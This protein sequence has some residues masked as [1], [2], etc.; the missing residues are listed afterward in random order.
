M[1]DFQSNINVNIDTANALASIKALQRQISVFHQEMAQGGAAAQASSAKMQQTLINGINASKGFSAE[2]TTISSSTQSFTNAL[3]KNKLSMGQY[4]RYSMGATKTFGS[5]FKTEFNTISKVARER[6]KDL[7]TQYVK[8]G[9]DGNGALQAIK[10]RPLTLDMKSL[11]TQTAMAAQKQQIFNQLIKQGSTNLLNFGKNTQWAGRQLMVGFTIPL[12]MMG[13]IAI[14]E[15]KKI[16]AQVIKFKRVYGDMFSTDADS[17]EAL[18]NVRRLADEFTKYGIA[19]EKTIGLAAKVAQMGNVGT[20]LEQ[21]VI[22]ATRLSV[23]GGLDQEEALDTTISLTNAFKVEVEDLTNKINFLNAAE[24]QTVL[25]IEDFNTAIPLAGSVVKSLGGEVEDLA[26]FLTAMREG[27]ISASQ[28]ANAL[29][30]SLARLIA[31]SEAAKQRLSEMGINVLGIVEANAGN[32]RGTVTSLAYALENL[33]PLSKARAIEQLFGKFQF[34]RMSTLFANIVDEGSQAN[35]VLGLTVNSAEELAILAE[36]ELGKVEDSSA[37]K[38]SKSLE[39]LKTSLAPIGETF[40]KAITPIV[41]WVANFIKKFDEMGEGTKNF[42][43]GLAAI[44]GA[45]APVLLMAIGLVANG[46]ANLI[47]FFQL[48]SNYFS[49]ASASSKT[50]GEGVS[51]LTQQQVEQLTVAASLDQVHN[52]LTQRFTAETLAVDGLSQAYGRAITTQNAYLASAAASASAPI[53]GSSR[54]AAPTTNTSRYN[55]FLPP[56]GYADGILSVPGPA[57]AGDVV[58]SMLSPGEAVIPA[59]R[60]KQYAPFI[61]GIIAGKIPGF[62]EGTPGAAAAVQT[63]IGGENFSFS[64][65]AQADR[66]AGLYRDMGEYGKILLETLKKS[67]DQSGVIADDFSKIK[68]DVAETAVS[69]GD[70]DVP[71]L[72]ATNTQKSHLTMPFEGDKRTAALGSVGFDK[73]PADLQRNTSAVSNLVA[74]L[75][76]IINQG[77]IEKVGPDGKVTGGVNSSLFEKTWESRPDKLD[78]T[79]KQG[80]LN[81]AD[82]KNVQATRAMDADI[83]KETSR[84]AKER[85]AAGEEVLITDRILAEATENIIAKNEELE[86]ATGDLARVMRERANSLGEARSNPGKGLVQKYMAEAEAGRPGLVRTG[87]GAELGFRTGEVD[88]QGS[89]KVVSR[90]GRTGEVSRAYGS[91][92]SMPGG[93]TRQKNVSQKVVADALDDSELRNETMAAALDDPHISSTKNSRKSPHPNAAIDGADDARAYS[94]ARDKVLRDPYTSG[95]APKLP[96]PPGSP[97]A[98]PTAPQVSTPAQSSRKQRILD[99]I[100]DSSPG[101]AVGKFLA[102]QSGVAVTD[103]KGQVFYDPNEDKSTWAGQMEAQRKQEELLF[104]QKRQQMVEESATNQELKAAGQ[105]VEQGGQKLEVAGDSLQNAQQAKGG[106]N[107]N[108]A[109]GGKRRGGNLAGGV[110]AMGSAAMMTQM[111]GGPVGEAAGAVAAPLMA[112]GGIMPMLS[113]LPPQ[114]QAAALALAAV[115]YATYKLITHFGNV[116]KK[117]AELETALGTGTKAVQKFAEFSGKVTSKEVMDR[118]IEGGIDPF[119][120]QPGKKT[121]GQGFF[122][123]DEGTAFAESVKQ[124]ISTLGTDQ[125]MSKVALQLGQAVAQ[126]ALDTSSAMSIAS[127]IGTQLGD[128]SFAIGVNSQLLSLIDPSGKDLLVDPIILQAKILVEGQENID[129]LLGEGPMNYIEGL[130]YYDARLTDVIEAHGFL[131][132]V[133]TQGD[134]WSAW[135]LGITGIGVAEQ[136]IERMTQIVTQSRDQLQSYGAALDTVSIEYEKRIADATERG[137]SQ[138]EISALAEEAIAKKEE[139]LAQRSATMDKLFA[140]RNV[141]AGQF[142]MGMKKG[143]STTFEGD[144]LKTATTL[145]NQIGDEIGKD[146]VGLELRY[147]LTTGDVPLSTISDIVSE[148]KEFPEISEKRIGIITDFGEGFSKEVENVLTLIDDPALQGQYLSL[149][150]PNNLA[151]STAALEGVTAAARVATNLVGGDPSVILDVYINDENAR[152]ELNASIDQLEADAASGVTMDLSYVQRTFGDEALAI[153]KLIWDDIDDD[154]QKDALYSIITQLGVQTTPGYDA[155]VDQYGGTQVGGQTVT[156]ANS[157]AAGTTMQFLNTQRAAAGSIINEEEDNGG[158]GKASSML[159]G[160][161]KK[162]RDL[163]LATIKV[164]KGFDAAAKTLEDLFA[165]GRKSINVFDGLEQQMRRLGAG[166]GLIEMIAGMDPDEYEKRKNELFSFDSGGNITG[167]TDRLKSVGAALNSISLGEYVNDQRKFIENTQNQFTAMNKLTASGMSYTEAFKAVQDTAFASAIAMAATAEELR[168]IVRITQQVTEMQ[169]RYNRESEKEQTINAIK[170]KNKEFDKRVQTLNKL[171]KA[172]GQY[173]DAQIEAI[174]GDSNLQAL[175][176]NPSISSADLQ[177]ALAN[178]EAQADLEL[179]IKKLTI[180]GQQSVWSDAMGNAQK[181]FDSQEQK[182]QM[183][184]DLKMEDDNKILEDAQNEIAKIQYEL[185]DYQAQLRD[186]GAQEDVINERYEKRFEALDKVGEANE[187]IARAQ[188]SQLSIADALSQGDIAAAAKAAQEARSTQTQDAADTQRSVLEAAQKAEIS[189]VKSSDGLN[190]DQVNEK[191]KSLEDQIFQIEE[192]RLEPAQER[193]R[194]GQIELKSQIEALT[195]L[196][197]TKDQWDAT[198]NAID[199]ATA[200][201]YK[202]VDSMKEGLGIVDELISKLAEGPPPPPPA[203][204]PQA[205]SRRGGGGGGGGG[206]GSSAPPAAPT[207][208]HTTSKDPDPTPA[209]VTTSG[210]TPRPTPRPAPTPAARGFQGSA[211]TSLGRF[212]AIKDTVAK[213]VTYVAKW[214]PITAVKNT[215]SA[216]K[217]FFTNQ[218]GG[219]M[220]IPSRMSVGGSVAKYAMGG[221]VQ[222][223]AAGGFSMG[224]DIVPAMLTPGEFVVRRPAV[225]KIGTDKLEQINRGQYS[226]GSVYNYNLAVNVR[227]NANPDAIA[228]TVINEI[229][230]VDNYRVR[231]NRF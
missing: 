117:T 122:E 177:R 109:P 105:A 21:Q 92:V 104:N 136:N 47:K 155:L 15:F 121:T 12:A 42:L 106:A 201:N 120:V 98:P 69:Q 148:Y 179:K 196:D 19:V 60:A 168:E 49:G 68:R 141:N 32:L 80:G 55:P 140:E 204:K 189:G 52:N 74:E 138:T 51:Y 36:R 13:A 210:I 157:L 182:L 158:G 118:R 59:D 146:G 166:E 16:E 25:S 173:T 181:A 81:M 112:L 197:K 17:E 11:G 131:K 211:A 191:V 186:I 1:A 88:D 43:V 62:V 133:F 218:S 82:P 150:D 26:F 96:P 135:W 99:A 45:I 101:K 107:A 185:D 130:E 30:T 172:Q 161:T 147:Q 57:G 180:G 67:A 28:G 151:D 39:K 31:P 226:D 214:N 38:F 205:S 223:L 163:R 219:G 94:E 125:T 73:L 8:L 231:G 142:D 115:G 86:G 134:A 216:I 224:S 54:S 199:L 215:V 195:V 227:S 20:A 145:F 97:L 212:A 102:K 84:I 44:G 123:G 192:Q 3:E 187:R 129:H 165:G 48:M 9:R 46:I 89:P 194:L 66:V 206:G 34:A 167:F 24:N 63:G 154:E 50:L 6:V 87:T 228:R 184:F 171:A 108:V 119:Q 230:R 128:R 75:P 95:G 152:N 70:W 127:E 2:L 91:N 139:I 110:F 176:L 78:A 5:F 72:S 164:A 7:Q 178:A 217:N 207:P 58:A 65:Q 225:S 35:K 27:G 90:V 170:D 198:A 37:T 229:K 143:L 41:E 71:G 202:F 160:L 53:A 220:I 162:L 159:D 190:R 137:W 144:D 156:D 111:A 132:S 23:L 221:K 22:Q 103:S 100:G 175:F 93:Y 222:G 64:S 124:G 193:V 200:S 77:L 85:T 153:A 33:D 29:K 79:A 126:G 169:E 83:L 18:E 116:S 40:L 209:V 183:Q 174:L 61:K 76:A 4:F 149:F 208:G 203:P 56:K 113:K 114:A 10:V 14:K 213:V 188:Q